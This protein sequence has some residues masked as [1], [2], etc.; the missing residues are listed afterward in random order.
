MDK[1]TA[2]MN[3]L[4]HE[5]DFAY[6]WDVLYSLETGELFRRMAETP[7]DPEWHGE[8]D[9]M[10]HTRLVCEALAARE[11]FRALPVNSQR[12]VA[13]AALLHDIGKTV[14]TKFEEG[15][16]TS[17]GHSATGARMAR[18]ML[19]KDFGLCGDSEKQNFRETVCT[20]IRYHSAPM[21][22]FD[23]EE[24]ERTFTRIAAEG[25]LAG[26]FTLEM[27]CILALADAAGRIAD[28]SGECME[29]VE[30]C[31][32]TVDDFGCLRGPAHFADDHTQRAY[33]K[34]RSVWRGQSLYDDTWG[35]VILL[36]GLP[37]TGK[38]TWISEQ[39]PEMNV[40]SL[41]DIRNRMGILPTDSQG[42]VAQAAQEQA[43]IYLRARLPF[44]W[45]A[46]NIT[47]AM[48]QK[49]VSLFED[50]GA[51]VR[52]V[53]LETGWDENLRRNADRKACVPANVIEHM[54]GKMTL[55]QRWE[56]RVVEWICV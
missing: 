47:Q 46:T 17:R 5:P 20:L 2:L 18:E 36:S 54:L 42:E 39:K 48:R 38:D 19:W 14:C 16:Y 22:I 24:T 43:R 34:G 25:N 1:S 32:Q 51:S 52:I 45:N 12:A 23:Q 7:Q 26:G 27:L 44:I 37:G 53:Y 50:Y 49:L 29:L 3:A 28:D 10:R 30:L 55:P 8:G 4:P 41:D 40:I 56:A 6:D 13:L 15:R 11:D 35:E 21:H 9:V 33:F 31:R